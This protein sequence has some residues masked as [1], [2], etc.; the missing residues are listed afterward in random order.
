LR[1]ERRLRVFDIRKFRRGSWLK[2]GEIKREQRRLHNEELK[3]LYSPTI[4]RVM[5]SRRMRWAGHVAL[6]SEERRIQGLGGELRERDDL[7]DP[8]VD[9]RIIL[10]F[11]FRKWNLGSW[12]VLIWLRTRTGGGLLRMRK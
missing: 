7:T 5:K 11:I 9:G 8:G 3:D 10:K 4:D 12:T 6:W 1:E 2:R